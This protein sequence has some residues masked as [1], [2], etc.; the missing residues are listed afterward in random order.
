MN[1][2]VPRGK[3]V[4]AVSGG[5]DSMTLLDLLS[6]LSGVELVVAHFNHGIRSDSDKDE[7]LVADAASRYGWPLEVGFGRLGPKTSEATARASRYEFFETVRLKYKT[8]KIITAHHQNDLIETALINILR[9]TNR[10]GLTAMIDNK[11]IVRPLLSFSKTE[12]LR[13]AK[14]NKLSWRD[15]PTNQQTDY[16]RNYLR[17]NV[18][19]KLSSHQ[20]AKLISNI[21]KT[22]KR[23]Q[24][25][26]QEIDSL[27]KAVVS[28]DRIDRMSYSGLPDK[29]SKELLVHWLRSYELGEIDS[30][31][32]DRLNLALK[33]ARPGTSHSVKGSASLKVKTLT[34]QFEITP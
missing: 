14:D 30:A 34:A 17:L 27:S 6:N 2:K 11:Q 12:I 28:R 32:V 29:I 3:Y 10:R 15:D 4:L 18:I 33:T 23:N 20:K 25:I 13:Y 24:L 5:V 31:E 1:V 9:G 19:P 22:A 26:N 21:N 7:E 16:L 8:K